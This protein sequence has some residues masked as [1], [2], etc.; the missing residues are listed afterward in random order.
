MRIQSAAF[1]H[2]GR[3]ANNE[4]SFCNDAELG[5]FAVADGMGGYEGGEVA[6]RLAIE[7]ITAFVRANRKDDNLTWPHRLDRSLSLAENLVSNA[8][9]LAHREVAR[10][11]IGALKDMGSTLSSIV[12]LGDR[13]VLGHVG[14]SRIYRLRGGVLAQLTN[15]HSVYG[16]LLRASGGQGLPPKETFAFAHMITRALGMTEEPRPDV[17]TEELLAGD[18]LL[19]CSDGLTDPLA[20]EEIGTL[21][22]DVDLARACE[23]LVAR[24]YDAGGKDNITVVALRVA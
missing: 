23:T 8:A 4:D 13:A 11:R 24:A 21:L 14:D 9:R 16:E 18:T 12:V 3:R 2:V 17:C 7:A 15:D 10:N 6:S 20:D 1:T 19:L 22:G 5:V